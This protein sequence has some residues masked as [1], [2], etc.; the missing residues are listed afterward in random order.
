MYKLCAKVEKYIK[1]VNL[2]WLSWR[3]EV[4]QWRKQQHFPKRPRWCWTFWQGGVAD[5]SPAPAF[6]VAHLQLMSCNL[7]SP[8]SL[9]QLPSHEIIKHFLIFTNWYV[10]TVKETC[11]D[12]NAYLHLLPDYSSMDCCCSCW[13]KDYNG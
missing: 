11:Y 9:L 10:E 5:E 3:I 7:P 1:R 2:K 13:L 8:P 4:L 6:V 12:I